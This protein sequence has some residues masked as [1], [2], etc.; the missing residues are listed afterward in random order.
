MLK[1]VQVVPLTGN[2]RRLFPAEAQVSVN[3]ARHKAMADQVATASK[4]RLRQK[5]GKLAYADLEGVERALK[6]QLRL[7]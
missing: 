4:L 2:M 6:I 3:G 5:I 1:R 7:S